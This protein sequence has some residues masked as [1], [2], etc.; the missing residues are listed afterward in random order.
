MEVSDIKVGDIFS[1]QSHYVAVSADSTKV[2]F[3]H[4]QSGQ[5][6]ML[7]TNYVAGMLKSA[8]QYDD[9]VEVGKEDK[10][11]T[12]KQIDEQFG[13]LG[14]LSQNT[15]NVGDVRVPGIRTIW[16]NIHSQQVF[17]VCFQKADKAKTQKALAAEYAA[18]QEMAVG[19]ID[20]AKKM[21]K[22]M[23]AAYKIAMDELQKNPIS[24]IVHG[25]DRVLRGYKLQFTS[26]DG[27]YDC[28][29]LDIEVKGTENGI[30]PVNINTLKW[31]IIDGVKYIVK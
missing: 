7:S 5:H 4:V 27:K 28:V 25:E 8:D 1:E 31:I 14:N 3:V 24:K 13:D 16:E 9:V 17:T 12:K 22:S 15:P 2:E 19:L 29:D 18:Q 10:L 21:K 23:A 26:R 6:V 11:W 30:R 20:K